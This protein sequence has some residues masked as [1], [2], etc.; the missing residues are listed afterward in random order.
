MINLSI[1]IPCYNESKSLSILLKNFSQKLNRRDIELIFVN[2][3]STDSTKSI[4]FNLKKKYN[5]LK[6][7]YVK[8]NIGYGNGIL[9]GLKKSKGNFM[10]WTHA[11]LQTD[12]YD[13]ILVFEKYK[14]ELSAKIFI[15]GIRLGRPL[16]DIFFTIAM[17]IFEMI[18]LKKIFWDINAQPNIIHK[19]FLKKLHNIPLDFSFDLFFYYN[20]KKQ[21]LKIY[22]YPV[23]FYKRKFGLSNWNTSFKNKMKLIKRTINY[24]FQLNKNCK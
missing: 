21:K 3:G 17:S 9:A 6:T 5:F 7:I 2:N 22:R 4:L 15:K 10:A 12:P 16:T 1:V 20:A 11:D 23:K 14:K 13:V 8:K 18:L 19:K 24:S